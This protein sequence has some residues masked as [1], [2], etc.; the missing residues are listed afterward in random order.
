MACAS[1]ES[2]TEFAVCAVLLKFVGALGAT[3]SVVALTVIGVES[4]PL[5]VAINRKLYVVTADNPVTVIPVA[6]APGAGVHVCHVDS[7][8]F[9]YCNV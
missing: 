1:H 4:P 7:V 2:E 9:L 8:D 5:F 6:L 3:A